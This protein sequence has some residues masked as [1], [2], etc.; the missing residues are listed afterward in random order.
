MPTE[1]RVGR[2]YPIFSI[3]KSLLRRTFVIFGPVLW[4]FSTY[5]IPLPMDYSMLSAYPNPFNPVTNIGFE[6]PEE[7][8]V[9]IIVYDL[10]GQEVATLVN[11]MTGAGRYSVNWDAND[12]A[13]GIYFVNFTALRDGHASVAKIQKLMLVK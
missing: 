2:S 3:I 8:M 9:N 13:S 4:Y 11:G 12:V 1:A 5:G 6:I 7:S 10:R